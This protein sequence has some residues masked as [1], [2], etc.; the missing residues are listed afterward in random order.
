M[1]A[2][3]DLANQMKVH[4]EREAGLENYA[5]LLQQKISALEASGCRVSS[6]GGGAGADKVVGFYELMTGMSVKSEGNSSF[7]CTLKNTIERKATRF[8]ISEDA[9]DLDFVPTANTDMLPDFLQ[10]EITFEKSQAPAML[11]GALMHLYD[12]EGGD[13]GDSSVVMGDE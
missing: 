9:D 13:G 1:E 6:T 11:A 2:E 12:G 8:T 7:T 5:S 3:T 4:K 10:S